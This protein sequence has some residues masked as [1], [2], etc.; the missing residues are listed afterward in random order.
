MAASS[1]ETLTARPGGSGAQRRLAV[2]HPPTSRSSRRGTFELVISRDAAASGIDWRLGSMVWGYD[3]RAILFE[4]MRTS[5]GTMP[6]SLLSRAFP[7]MWLGSAGPD[8]LPDSTRVR[9]R[10]SGGP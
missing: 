3:A 1:R 10:L 6:A 4:I 2:P 8:D 5:P 9:L 7:V